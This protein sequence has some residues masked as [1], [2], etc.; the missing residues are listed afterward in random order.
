M[1]KK[2]VLNARDEIAAFV[3]RRR[4]GGEAE[5]VI[6][7]FEGSFNFCLRVTF[8]DGGPDAVIR[9]PGP[10]HTT[11]RDEKTAN[12]VQIIKFLHEL[13]TIPVPCLISWG[14]T[15]DSPK[16]FGPFI[17]S[18]FAEGVHLSGILRDPTDQKRL[19]LN[20][21]IDG[22]TLDIIFD[23]IA[24][25]ILQLFQF[26][27]DRIGAMSKD[28]ASNTWSVTGRLLTYNMNELATT[29]FYPVDKTLRLRLNL[30]ATTL[31]LSYTNI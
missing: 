15:K 28:P 27:F 22:R 19:Y 10:G 4:P 6:D 14:L 8:N 5:N 23:Q 31:G 26:N 24:D 12:E 25:I 30:Q 29:A 16:H 3:A 7:W 13:T 11:F 1:W 18:D 2:Q 17:I 21:K 20:P 9:F